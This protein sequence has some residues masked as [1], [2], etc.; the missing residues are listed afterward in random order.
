MKK[1]KIFKAA[2]FFIYIVFKANSYELANPDY[3]KKMCSH[4]LLSDY[5]LYDNDADSC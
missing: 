2:N 4:G 3:Y 1:I 5:I